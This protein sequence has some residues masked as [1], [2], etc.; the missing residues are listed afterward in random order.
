MNR[1][2]LLIFLGGGVIGGGGALAMTGSGAKLPGVGVELPDVDDVITTPDPA[3]HPWDHTVDQGGI[4]G[5]AWAD[6]W[7]LRVWINERHDIEH[8]RV[9]NK[10]D[11]DGGIFGKGGG[12]IPDYDGVVSLNFDKL[13]GETY[14]TPNF[15]VKATR[16]I[17]DEYETLVEFT[18]TL[19]VGLAGLVTEDVELPANVAQLGG[20][21]YAAILTEAGVVLKGEPLGSATE[22]VVTAPH[23][24][25]VTANAESGDMRSGRATYFA[26]FD[27]TPPG[28]Y[29]IEIYSTT[30]MWVPPG[31]SNRRLEDSHTV[32]LAK[33]EG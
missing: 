8:L 29:T 10:Y 28:T 21:F 11:S 9:R 2:T 32:D 26:A 24:E 31:E 4:D 20:Q 30:S 27:S 18:V 17:V 12:S 25:E 3:N 23:G 13:L 6:T 14:P 16:G 22:V 19:P 7:T 1:R 33:G 15:V 5:Y